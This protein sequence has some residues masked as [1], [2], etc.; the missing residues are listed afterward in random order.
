MG[1]MWVFLPSTHTEQKYTKKKKQGKGP[2]GKKDNDP[3]G[4]SKKGGKYCKHAYGRFDVL[5]VVP[6]IGLIAVIEVDDGH[7]GRKRSDLDVRKLAFCEENKIK[8]LNVPVGPQDEPFKVRSFSAKVR[9]Q[10]C[11]LLGS[12]VAQR[13]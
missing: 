1:S 12:K 4:V 7:R 2:A 9:R 11:Q 13:Q 6:S 3:A 10:F 5:A 8:I